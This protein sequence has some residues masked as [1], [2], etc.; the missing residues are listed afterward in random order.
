[1]SESSA[2]RAAKVLAPTARDGAGFSFESASTIAAS[3]V[4]E[5]A[6]G[7]PDRLVDREDADGRRTAVAEPGLKME[8]PRDRS[9][10]ESR[11]EKIK[12]PSQLLA[13]W[14][15]ISVPFVAILAIL[16]LYQ[17]KDAII[18]GSLAVLAASLVSVVLL[19]LR[20]PDITKK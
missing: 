1:M 15:L 4:V 16:A 13:L 6:S 9:A 14:V 18:W 10:A 11:I 8:I 5:E 3:I 12:T 17:D 20:P 7:F 19:G 2:D